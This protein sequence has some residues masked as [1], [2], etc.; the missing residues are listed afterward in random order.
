MKSFFNYIKYF[1]HDVRRFGW[2]FAVSRELLAWFC[3]LTGAKEFDI[4]YFEEK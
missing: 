2:R 4:K 3:Y 1:C